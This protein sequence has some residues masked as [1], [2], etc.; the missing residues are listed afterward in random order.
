VCRY[1][2][3]IPAH[4]KLHT[5]GLHP[6]D[7][8]RLCRLF[9]Q[10]PTSRRLCT[11]IISTWHILRRFKD[12]NLSLVCNNHLWEH[13]NF[14]DFIDFVT[15]AYTRRDSLKTMYRGA[16]K[17]LARPGR[18]QATSMSKSS[19]MINPTRSREMPSCSAIDLTEI[20]R[21]S[22]I[23]SWIWSII[24]GVIGLRTY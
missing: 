3:I 20:R 17:Y 2:P 8:S 5:K 16:D 11:A 15:L 12:Y 1:D 21:S 22:K 4:R 19:W 14:I 18:K 24:S 6:Q 23:S 10:S 7:I 9:I 13:F